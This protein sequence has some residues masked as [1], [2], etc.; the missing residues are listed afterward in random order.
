MLGNDVGESITKKKV[1]KMNEIHLKYV[2]DL[3]L[4]E[5]IDMTTQLSPVPLTDRPQPDAYRARTGHSLI[6]EKSKVFKQLHETKLYADQ[7][8]MKLNLAKTKLMLFNPCTSKDFMPEMVVE[9]KKIELVEQVKL[10]GVVLSSNLSWSVNTDYIVERCN[11]KM[12]V[13][14]RLKRLGASHTDLLEVFE[15]T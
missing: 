4:A 11:K 15:T 6:N 8:K 9:N 7:N 12:W 13:L 14:R 1:K 10:L 5:S 2:D 3:S